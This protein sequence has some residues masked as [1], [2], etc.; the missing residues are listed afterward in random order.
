M[1]ANEQV[2]RLHLQGIPIMRIMR[3]KAMTGLSYSTVRYAINKSPKADGARS[4]PQAEAVMQAKVDY[5]M[6]SRKLCDAP[7]LRQATRAAGFWLPCT[8][9]PHCTSYHAPHRPR[10]P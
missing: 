8:A 9:H 1:K 7:D 4:K 3:I 10:K 2:V 5:A 6:M